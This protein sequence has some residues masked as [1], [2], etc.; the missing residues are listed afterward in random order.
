ME[1]ICWRR[2]P[3]RC[4]RRRSARTRSR[5][6]PGSA[7]TDSSFALAQKLV[8]RIE[9]PLLVDADGLNALAAAE[10]APAARRSAPLV[11]TPHAGELARLLGTGSREVEAG[12]LAA[13]RR[14]A[15]RAG[16]VIVL[17]GDDTLVL[18]A[19]GA[20]ARRSAGAAARRSPPR[21]R[22]TCSPV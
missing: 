17:K 16:A 11:F 20:A 1:A 18:P 4:W 15:E 22:G 12:R 8:E 21:A 5:S 3:K 10:L 14:A 7:A 2:P 6:D 13:G 9:Q 19:G